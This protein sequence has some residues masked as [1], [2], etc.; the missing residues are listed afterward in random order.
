MRIR[1]TQSNI[2]LDS[3]EVLVTEPPEN[4]E[5]LINLK[6]EDLEHISCQLEKAEIDF[7][8]CQPLSSTLKEVLSQKSFKISSSIALILDKASQQESSFKKCLDYASKCHS[9]IIN[10][11]MILQYT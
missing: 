1:T 3:E 9:S 11:L 7:R 4:K 8:R 2:K 5:V 10:L 6:D